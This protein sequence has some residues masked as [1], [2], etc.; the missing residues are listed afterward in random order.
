ME[1]DKKI[2]R[3]VQDNWVYGD[4]KLWGEEANEIIEEIMLILIK[5]R[6]SIKGSL[7]VLEDTKEAIMKEAIL[8]ERNIN[9]KIIQVDQ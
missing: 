7:E 2:P 8:G 5:N 4:G 1:N 6:I 3:H 9:G